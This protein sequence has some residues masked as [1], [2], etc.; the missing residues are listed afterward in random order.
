MEGE[1]PLKRWQIMINWSTS[2]ICQTLLYVTCPAW[3]TKTTVFFSDVEGSHEPRTKVTLIRWKDIGVDGQLAEVYGYVR[4]TVDFGD[5][6]HACVRWRPSV[7]G[8]CPCSID[9]A[10]GEEF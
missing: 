4:P 1:L 2:V 3:F 8:I 10:S 5:R 6:E 9:K 7:S